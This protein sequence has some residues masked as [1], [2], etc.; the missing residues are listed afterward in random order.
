ML[1]TEP[2]IHFFDMIF[3]QRFEVIYVLVQNVL[4]KIAK[5]VRF[6]FSRRLG[7]IQ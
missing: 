6:L 5:V 1:T 2:A 3:K 4:V 7:H